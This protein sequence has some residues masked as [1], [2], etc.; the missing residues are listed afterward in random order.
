[1]RFWL[2][3][4]KR[5]TT[6]PTNIRKTLNVRQ[7]HIGTFLNAINNKTLDPQQVVSV[8]APRALCGEIPSDTIAH[9][10]PLILNPSPSLLEHDLPRLSPTGNTRRSKTPRQ[11]DNKPVSRKQAP[12]LLQTER[13]PGQ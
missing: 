8:S 7:R 2:K 11:A 9:Y 1:H 4:E 6:E 10:Q 3:V 13:G 5:P 12:T